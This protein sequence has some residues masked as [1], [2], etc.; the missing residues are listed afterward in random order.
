[1][2]GLDEEAIKATYQEVEIMRKLRH[3]NIITFKDVWKTNDK[4]GK[5]LNILMEYADDG[6]V[7]DKIMEK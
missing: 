5:S 4:M 7:E 2:S 3:P 6:T 1:M